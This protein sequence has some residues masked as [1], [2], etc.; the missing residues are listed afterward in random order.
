MDR[1]KEYVFQFERLAFEIVD[2]EELL[3]S[4]RHVRAHEA[5]RKGF[6]YPH[7]LESNPDALD[8][9]L[10]AW[11]FERMNEVPGARL[12]ARSG[13]TAAYDLTAEE[14]EESFDDPFLW[15]VNDEEDDDG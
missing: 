14:Y 2:E 11:G 8:V 3:Q 13:K 12:V 9:H 1:V 10:A 15:G 4:A 6:S 7:D 5:P